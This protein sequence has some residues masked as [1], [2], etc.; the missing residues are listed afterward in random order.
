MLEYSQPMHAFD[1][2][3][4]KNSEIVVRRA[5]KGETITTFDGV[6]R[7]LNGETPVIVDAEK[8]IVIA[9]VMGGKYSSIM[10]DT[11]TSLLWDYLASIL[12]NIQIGKNSTKKSL[13]Q[14]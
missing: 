1:L 7:K 12:E 6:Q 10:E 4:I 8:T 9:G 13:I 14:C 3:H 11:A 2:R 5:D